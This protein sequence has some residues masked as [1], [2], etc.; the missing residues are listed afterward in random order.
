[1]GK[2]TFFAWFMTSGERSKAVLKSAWLHSCEET[3]F[4]VLQRVWVNCKERRHFTETKVWPF[5][6]PDPKVLS[7]TKG[8]PSTDSAATN[9]CCEWVYLRSSDNK[10]WPEVLVSSPCFLRD[11]Q[12]GSPAGSPAR[13][14]RWGCQEALPS[15]SI[16]LEKLS[17]NAWCDHPHLLPGHLDSGFFW[18]SSAKSIEVNTAFI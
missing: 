11:C 5:V 16:S 15:G 13:R 2:S 3:P 4:R 8:D 14:W 7:D 12:G 10:E 9:A 6:F 1:M 17:W 18:F